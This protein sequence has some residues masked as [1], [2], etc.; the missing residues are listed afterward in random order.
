LPPSPA[1]GFAHVV[2]AAHVSV[3]PPLH[4]TVHAAAAPQT[5]VHPV[6]PWQSA[7][8]PPFGQLMLQ[9]LL[10]V[11]ETV[12]PVSTVTVHLLP[13]PQVTLLFVPVESVHSLVPV[14]VDEHP[15]VHV[16]VQVDWP[17][18]VV[19]QPL[20][21]VVSQLFFDSHL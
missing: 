10:P 14:Q 13:P 19:V 12:E 1:H 3:L 5:I 17:L 16:P 11:Q 15:S 7:V 9:V 4:L 8:Q 21:H 18:Q 2:P 6:L 20:P